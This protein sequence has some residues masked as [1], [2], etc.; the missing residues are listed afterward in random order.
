[1]VCFSFDA[2]CCFLC[3]PNS[4]MDAVLSVF[5]VSLCVFL[6]VYPCV[7]GCVY[8]TS[9]AFVFSCAVVCDR[10]RACINP[11][12][13][14]SVAA[15]SVD[16]LHPP[17]IDDMVFVHASG[18]KRPGCVIR[19]ADNEQYMH[20]MAAKLTSASGCL[21][22]SPVSR[23]NGAVATGGRDHRVRVVSEDS[24][25]GA[26]GAVASIGAI[27]GVAATRRPTPVLFPSVPPRRVS[28]S[29]CGGVPINSYDC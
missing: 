26:I 19:H 23:S 1:M 16:S 14:R 8:A 9:R 21:G 20:A 2:M 17:K 25:I 18:G 6:I 7:F 13:I 24:A 11:F 15:D 5:L 27:G 3:V 12:P 22:I 28:V 29:F 10:G 4:N